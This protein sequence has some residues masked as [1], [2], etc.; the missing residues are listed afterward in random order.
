MITTGTF[1][2]I[3]QKQA[4]LAAMEHFIEAMK[5]EIIAQ[6]F[7]I[8][9]LVT[10]KAAVGFLL[11]RFAGHKWHRWAVWFCIGTNGIMATW[12]TIAV[13]IQCLPIQ[14]TWNRL[15]PG[16]CWLDFTTVGIVT[17]GKYSPKPYLG[18]C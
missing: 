3:G 10:A 18:V 1:Y 2:G 8:F 9:N 13:F 5:Y 17:S 14:K 12:C 7:C 11:L 4:D 16:N 6:G 15:L